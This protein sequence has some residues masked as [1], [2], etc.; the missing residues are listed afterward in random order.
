MASIRIELYASKLLSDGRHPITVTVSKDKKIKRK[1]IGRAFVKEWDPVNKLLN[2]KKH[3]H[4]FENQEITEQ[5]QYYKKKYNDL[6]FSGN[7]WDAEDVFFE[8]APKA[9]ESESSFQQVAEDYLS[10]LDPKS[11]Y[12]DT[13]KGRVNKI[14]RFKPKPFLISAIDAQWIKEFEKHCKTKEKNNRGEK[15]NSNN[16]INDTFGTIKA[17][18]SFAGQINMALNKRKNKVDEVIRLKLTPAEML[19]VENLQL[20]GKAYHYRN[21]FLVQ[22]YGR[23]MR[24]GD[25]LRLRTKYFSKTHFVYYTGKSNKPHSIKMVPKL[26]LILTEYLKGDGFLWPFIHG[27]VD[28]SKDDLNNQVTYRTTK[29]NEALADIM[30]TLGIDKKITTHNARHS[31][32]AMADKKLGGDLKDVQAML[33]HSSRAMTERYIK[34]LRK[35]DEMDDLADKLFD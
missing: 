12:Y 34:E 17:I 4:V 10:T 13:V 16:T 25:V 21:A 2:K 14:K 30:K 9:K 31:F 22:Y 18:V 1:T 19:A 5:Y 20:T 6:K 35:S 28:Q 8:E 32:A 29:I 27:E 23:G 33:G 11:G 3:S 15:G 26:S 7:E 24:I